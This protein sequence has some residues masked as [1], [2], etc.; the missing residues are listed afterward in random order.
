[1]RNNLQGYFS[2][3]TIAQPE[4]VAVGEFAGIGIQNRSKSLL[5]PGVKG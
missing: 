5:S 2:K 1:M 3:L 4:M